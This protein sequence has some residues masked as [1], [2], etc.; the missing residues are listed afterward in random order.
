MWTC[1]ESPE[2]CQQEGDSAGTD[3]VCIGLAFTELTTSHKGHKR[4]IGPHRFAFGDSQCL[5]S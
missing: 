5:C 1:N 4:S 2:G 3:V